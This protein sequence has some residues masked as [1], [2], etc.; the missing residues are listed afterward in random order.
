MG[1]GS[2][3]ASWPSKA[4]HPVLNLGTFSTSWAFLCLLR[5][6]G[7]RV[8]VPW[9]L[10]ETPRVSRHLAVPYLRDYCAHQE[11]FPTTPLDNVIPLASINQPVGAGLLRVDKELSHEQGR[12]S[13]HV[14]RRVEGKVRVERGDICVEIRVSSIYARHSIFPEPNPLDKDKRSPVVICDTCVLETRS[15]M[16]RKGWI[17]RQS[18]GR[19]RKQSDSDSRTPPKIDTFV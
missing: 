6:R 2:S 5:P 15:C 14:L 11:F 13:V 1:W 19:E 4:R 18:R 3:K 12:P 16:V 17:R 8:P 10:V 9:R 7:V